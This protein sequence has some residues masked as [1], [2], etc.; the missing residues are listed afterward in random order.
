MG[1][2]D[3][4]RCPVCDQAAEA[5]AATQDSLT[6][7]VEALEDALRLHRRAQEVVA[8]SAALWTVSSSGY[9]AGGPVDRAARRSGATA[10]RDGVPAVSGTDDL[11]PP[12][13]GSRC[14]ARSC[15]VWRTR[16]P[17][18]RRSSRAD[19][20]LTARER[21]VLAQVAQGCTNRQIARRL[22]ISEKTVKNHLSAI[23]EKIG[24]A[25]RTQAALYAIRA[26]LA[27]V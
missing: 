6:D 19:R 7:A 22:G 3:A 21:E 24:V 4:G 18:G 17:A 5:V 9:P 20:D 10:A 1:S 26:G 27:P 11:P 23:F 2:R 16:P 13:P 25:D 8:R 15:A 12:R 14:A